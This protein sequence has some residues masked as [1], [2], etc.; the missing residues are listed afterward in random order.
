MSGSESPDENPGE[1][2][3]PAPEP[4]P[5]RRLGRWVPWAAVGFLAA[6][7]VLVLIVAVVRPTWF[8]TPVD[9]DHAH[10]YDKTLADIGRTDG[11]YLSDDNSTSQ[12]FTVPVPQDSRLGQPILRLEGSTEVGASSTVFLRVLADGISVYVEELPTGE[13]DLDARIELPPSTT[14]DGS[15]RIQVRTTGSTDQQQCNLTQELGALV[16]LD[17]TGTLV[18]GGLDEPIHTVRDVVASLD[19]DVALVLAFPDEDPEWFETAARIATSLT[20][21]GHAVAY[22]DAADADEVPDVTG[23]P[24]LLGP[25]DALSALGWDPLD[26][27]ADAPASLAVGTVSDESVLGVVAP[28]AEVTSTFLTTTAV[29]TADTASSAPRTE[30]VAGLSGDTVTLESL[31]A[32]TSVQSVTD[33]RSWRAAYSL[34]DLPGG[35]VPTALELDLQVPVTTAD[36]RWLVQVRLNDELVGSLRLPGDGAQSARVPLPEAAELLRNELTVTLIRDRD[37]GG[38]HVRQ[39]AYDVQLLP[40]TQLVLGGDGAGFTAV[41]QS[42]SD[43]FDVDL[44]TAALADAATSLSG[45]VPTL[46]EFSGWEQQARFVWDGRPGDEPFLLV[47]APPDGL[48]APVTVSDGR[49]EADGF[50]LQSFADGVVVQVVRVGGVDSLVL[51]PVGTPDDLVPPYGRESARLVPAGGGGFVVDASGQ[52]VSAPPVRSESGG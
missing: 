39:T 4:G 22:V 2:P 18:D 14:A 23:T 44:P 7:I 33:R 26:A 15:V 47:D 17:A 52:V 3:A 35:S 6:A 41:P 9:E 11:I 28:E 34:A 31:G 48:G 36:A 51:T 43:G 45:L 8:T 40:S 32:D 37:V 50:D 25:T 5:A 27:D 12:T 24:I 19:H 20:Q 46:A 30:T 38:C 16:H 42:F 13:N 10:P 29:T 21:Q 49:V 1:I